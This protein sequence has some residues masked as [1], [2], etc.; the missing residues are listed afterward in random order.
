MIFY[1]KLKKVKAI[2]F[3][4]DDTLYNNYPII[5]KANH[6]LF[7]W[8]EKHYPE[9]KNT[10]EYFWKT[11]QL[12]V[13]RS[14]PMLKHDMGQLRYSTMHSGFIHLGLL[15]EAAKEAAQH[16]FDYFYFQR[17]NFSLS[18]NIHSLLAA[19]SAK[20][21]LVAITNGN[22]NLEQ[23]GIAPYFSKT[24]KA[25]LTL[26]MKPNSAMFEASKQFLKLPDSNILHVGDD[27]HKDVWGA[28]KS[29]YQTA[30]YAENRTMALVNEHATTIPHVQ[31]DK[32]EEL[33]LLI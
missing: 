27:L 28:L 3:D 5:V 6:A 14:K 9:T 20:L 23:I 12:N 26:P 24:L 18:K 11:H 17:S 8:L 16:S 29:G 4:L 30:W 33:L 22:V 13:L 1:K 21:P 32:L 19:L 31:L 15:P 2:T 7:A 25:S 10:D